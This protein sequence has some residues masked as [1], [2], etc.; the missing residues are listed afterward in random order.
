M[1]VSSAIGIA[2]RF[3]YRWTKLSKER[4]RTSSRASELSSERLLTSP[5][6]LQIRKAPLRRL[7]TGIRQITGDARFYS[8]F[9]E[10]FLESE[11]RFPGIQ[12]GYVVEKVLEWGSSADSITYVRVAFRTSC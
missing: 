5:V 12:G 3:Y 1:Y 9:G 4:S 11:S 6:P 2:G 8:G 10:N 7:R